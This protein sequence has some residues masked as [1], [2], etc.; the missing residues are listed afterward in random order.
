MRENYFYIDRVYVEYLITKH[1]NGDIDWENINLEEHSI[2][3]ELNILI[4]SINNPDQLN[5]Q[6][7][8]DLN[9]YRNNY[10][11]LKKHIDKCLENTYQTFG[12]RYNN[13]SVDRLLDYLH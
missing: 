8:I 4:K 13:T 11:G 5:D 3:D 9:D 2:L 7:N 6:K 12:I 1:I 10:I